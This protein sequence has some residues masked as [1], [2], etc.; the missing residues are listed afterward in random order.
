VRF[1][2]TALGSAGDK[3]VG[4][5][6]GA[7][8]RYLISPAQRSDGPAAPAPG[9]EAAG[10]GQESVGRYYADSGDSPGRWMGQGARE[11]SLAG[12]VDF[13]DFTTVLAGRA[14]RTGE[15]L[16]TARGSAGRVA[17][18]GSGS[19]A[20]WSPAGETL[21]SIRDVAT[22]LGWTQA[23]VRQAIEEGEHLAATRAIA[24]L[25]GTPA[26]AG[27]ATPGGAGTPSR[28]GPPLGRDDDRDARNDA[29]D[30]EPRPG[31]GR[32]GAGTS[33]QDRAADGEHDRDPGAT[34][35]DPGPTTGTGR[36]DTGMALVPHIDRDGSRYVGEAELSRVE[37]LVARGVS[38]D[39]VLAG[40]DPDEELS[41]PAAARLVGTS[42]GYLSRLCRSYL[43]H[44]PEIDAKLA[45]G[46]T[47]K[48]AYVVCR[49]D[50]DGNYRVTRADLAAYADRRRRPAVRVGYDVTATAEKSISVLALLGGAHVRHEA[51]AAVEAANDTGMRWLERHAAAARAGG[52]V[53]GVTGWTV[54]SF[55]HLTS[56]RLDPF[57][58]HHN[59]VA[60]TVLDEHGDRRALD[61]RR[62]YRNVT[63]AS[64][65]ATAQVRYE[66]TARLGVTYRP[67]HRGGWEIDGITDP[68]LDEFSQR[69][70]E[71]NDAIR[72][73]EEALGR[74]STLDE[75]NNVVATQRRRLAPSR[76]RGL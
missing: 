68:V 28:P 67:G 14:P 1:T 48:R 38:S 64:A 34:G 46:E 36:D 8:A 56:R 65:I 16:I 10:N 47:P 35:T 5:V 75:L 69:R 22:V 60:N 30:L 25:S 12:T 54:A 73:L 20:R 4:A 63:A 31:A 41:V 58:H 61:A 32:D 40:G 37:A 55:Q 33:G 59:V 43:E 3:P 7:I 52:Q 53:V 11:V 29:P 62:L 57:V 66:L 24:A 51:L 39:E 71:I 2:V 42:R 6:V 70:R 21:Y 27:P 17:S 23:D 26:A 15:R 18:L 9:T 45:A 76:G 50:R 13:D 44:Q 74:A 19:V 49:R 72:E